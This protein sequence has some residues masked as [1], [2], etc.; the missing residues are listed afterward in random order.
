MSRRP[1][2]SWPSRHPAEIGPLQR[3]E[4]SDAQW[5]SIAAE[6]DDAQNR[7]EFRGLIE[8][9][10]SCLI[11]ARQNPEISSSGKT[12]PIGDRRAMSRVASSARR[13]LLALDELSGF[14]RSQLE[15]TFGAGPEDA[16]P[17]DKQKLGRF[18]DDLSYMADIAPLFAKL[19][20][21]TDGREIPAN[22][23]LARNETWATATSYWER[24]TRKRA[25]A[26]E[27]SQA[28]ARAPA[29]GK[30]VSFLQ[31]FTEAIP[32]ERRPKGDE[33]RWFLRK[34][35]LNGK[36]KRWHLDEW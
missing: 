34:Y 29:A 18:K 20:F 23:D 11:Y 17:V 26:Y 32:G 22:V 25:A 15:G 8:F 35:W 1:A 24:A 12:S 2:T 21:R 14:A 10:A 3:F 28:S 9:T 4:F 5:E 7:D 6:M 27:N 36:K 13:L 31:A 30:I 19:G 33:I 16:L